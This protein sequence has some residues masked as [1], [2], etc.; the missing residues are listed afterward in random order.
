VIKYLGSKRLLVPA[1][2]EIADLLPGVSK[3]LDLFSGTARVGHAFKARGYE[4]VSNDH[5]AF[6]QVFAACYV[7]ADAEETAAPASDLLLDLQEASPVDGWFTE[8]YAR[9]A[10][11]FRPER[12][13]KIEGIRRRIEDLRLDPDLEAVCLTSLIEAADRV[14]STVGVQM[15]YLKEYAPRTRRPVE[16]RMPELLP[17]KGEVLGLD[18]LD[19]AAIEADLVYLDP[20][21][22]QHSYLG[23]YHV[24]ETLARFDR[25]EVYGVACK[26][27]DCKT[28]KSPFNRKTEIRG[29]LETL[30]ARITAPHVL[31]SFNDEGFVRPEDIESMLRARGP[32]LRLEIPYRRY[33]GA[34]IGIHDGK[35]RKVGKPGRLKNTEILWLSSPDPSVCR[36]VAARF[37]SSEPF[38]GESFMT[39]MSRGTRT[40]RRARFTAISPLEDP[41]PRKMD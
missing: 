16:L 31:L 21:Y 15:A 14:D 22:N 10:R 39:A 30:L 18:A 1:I 38:S 26:R 7:G 17:G 5:N 34:R 3:V 41:D 8:F 25:P 29:A 27:V 28:R 23:N 19:A 37:G 20:P 4:V 6:A 40:G 24:W 36:E 35:G 2:L 32:F 33:V 11:Y 13:A 9:R 12:A